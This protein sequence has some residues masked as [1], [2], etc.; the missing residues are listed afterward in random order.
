MIGR[1]GRNRKRAV[2]RPKFARGKFLVAPEKFREMI[3][4]GET[5]RLPYLRKGQRL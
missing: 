1:L 4:V 5:N 3:G 2:L